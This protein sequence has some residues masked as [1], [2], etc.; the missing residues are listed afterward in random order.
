MP[1]SSPDSHC[2][3]FYFSDLDTLVQVEES[4]GAVVV[5]A[6]R[7]S[8]SER[9]K[10][11]FIRELAAEGF[12]PDSYRWF[13]LASSESFRGVRWVVDTSWVKLSEVVTIRVRCFMMRLFLSSTLLLV[14]LA[15]IL[16]LHR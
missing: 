6:T 10:Q 15:A 2:F 4:D 12:I 11:C 16:I 9:R 1:T 5:R 14:T 13:L 3:E 8:V 7:D